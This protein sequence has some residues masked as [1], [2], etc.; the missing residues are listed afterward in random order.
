MTDGATDWVDWH[1]AYDDPA[2]SL[3][4]RLDIVRHRIGESL[5]ALAN[6]ARILSLCAG[7]GRDLIPVIARLPEPARPTVRLVEQDERLAVAAEE[8]AVLAGVPV[9]V[10]VG[11]ASDPQS[12]ADHLPVDLLLLCGIFG[13]VTAEDIKTTIDAVPTMVA[14]GGFVIWTRGRF[15]PDLRPTIRGWFHQAGLGEVAFDGE[16][17]SYGVGVNRMPAA[18][19]PASAAL[20]DRLFTFLR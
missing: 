9:E 7:D 5:T 11:D 12:F 4:Q 16:P 13:N 6:D 10:V 2:S 15:D 20:P 19:L 14:P 8:Q 18:P 17:G 1:G 3:S